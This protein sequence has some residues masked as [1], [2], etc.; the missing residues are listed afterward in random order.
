MHVRL[1]VADRTAFLEPVVFLFFSIVRTGCMRLDR[2]NH[3][4]F[5]AFVET[6]IMELFVLCVY[7]EHILDYNL[8][9]TLDLFVETSEF[10]KHLEER[11]RFKDFT[12][13]IAREYAH[14]Q[15]YCMT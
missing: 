14:H 12:G 5:C 15:R 3:V 13:G 11:L 7:L 6:Q 2:L 8:T 9:P 4:L 10:C 1:W